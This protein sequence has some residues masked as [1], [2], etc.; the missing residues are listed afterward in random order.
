M[1]QRDPN[2]SPALTGGFSAK[3]WLAKQYNPDQTIDF[4]EEMVALAIGLRSSDIHLENEL[5]GL[6]LRLRIDG[7]LQKIVT[8]DKV[9]ARR[10]TS[11]FKGKCPGIDLA[12][13]LVPQ[14]GSFQMTIQNKS[15]DFRLSSLPIFT[16]E[17]NLVMRILDKSS[18]PNGLTGLGI[19][20]DVQRRLIAVANQPNGMVISTGPTGSG[21]TTTQYAILT[22]LNDS[23]RKI[24]TVEDPVE[25]KLKG[26]TQV[27]VNV[28]SGLTFARALRAFLRH[29]PEI[30][31][32]GE[33][34]DLE[35]AEIS[36]EAALTGHLVLS[37]L[38]TN[39]A[40]SALWRLVDMGV[41]PFLISATVTGV[42]AQRLARRLCEHCKVPFSAKPDLLGFLGY[43]PAENSP[44]T[45]YRPD[46]Q[47]FA[48]CPN[49]CNNGFIKRVGIYEFLE[50]SDEIRSMI[51]HKMS[52]QD[53]RRAAHNIGM[54]SLKED[55]LYKVL[56]GLTT[57]DEVRRVIFTAGS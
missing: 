43:A 7:V 31:M 33:V 40:P 10:I 25:Y 20:D 34:R 8:F 27:Q 24:L 56:A 41:E 36:V 16:G 4:I 51:T 5:E 12:N 32:V 2:A 52:T 42:L 3:D 13:S 44:I 9:N 37:T 46:P 1:S 6:T 35:T 55:A 28:K 30:I 18:L 50:L 14:D 19:E 49:T 48:S 47:K 23:T 26:T 45:L 57:A 54:K 22:T 39:D 53:I 17:E 11:C 38:H 21:K 15:Y 29:D